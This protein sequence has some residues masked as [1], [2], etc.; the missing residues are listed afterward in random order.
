MGGFGPGISS[1]SGLEL[2]KVLTLQYALVVPHA[3]DWRAAAVYQAGMEFNHPLISRKVTQHGGILPKRWGLLEVSHPNVVTST[4]KPGRDGTT[5]L[6]V[7]EAT[8]KATAGVRTKFQAKVIAANEANLMEDAG[9]K[10]E[11]QNDTLQLDLGPYEIKTF[12][13]ELK[14]TTT[15]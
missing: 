13:L 9:R 10:V 7:Y 1:D 11:I 3:G 12:K 15:D 14:R 5:V 8:G 2:G 4:L 6:R